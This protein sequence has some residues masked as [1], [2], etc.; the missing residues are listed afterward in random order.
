MSK[1]FRIRSAKATT[2]SC[3]GKGDGARMFTAPDPDKILWKLSCL[4]L[5]LLLY[6]AMLN[7]F[8]VLREDPAVRKF[9]IG[10]LLFAEVA[11]H[12]HDGWD[13]QWAN[14]DHMVHVLTGKRVLRT[15]TG[16]WVARPGDTFFLKK[17]TISMTRESRAAFTSASIR[18]P[19]R[20][21]ES[22]S[23]NISSATRSARR[24]RP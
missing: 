10:D 18:K 23:A 22:A 12:A 1:D 19:A 8:E 7:I 4:C 21:R 24:S 2:N 3:L 9:R 20:A 15:C 16:K 6:L 11:C 5:Y 13:S 14:V 17:G